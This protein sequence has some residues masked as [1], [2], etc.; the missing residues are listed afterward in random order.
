MKK[1]NGTRGFCTSCV[2]KQIKKRLGAYLIFGATHIALIFFSEAVPP[3]TDCI[4][5]FF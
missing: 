2:E 1:K 5:G 3:A 4:S